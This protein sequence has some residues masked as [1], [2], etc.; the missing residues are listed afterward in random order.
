[1]YPQLTLPLTILFAAVAAWLVFLLVRRPVLRRLALRQVVRRP[2]ELVLVILGSMLGTALIVASL[3]V[4]DSLDRSVRQSAYD[5]LG[6]VD[7]LVRSP[8]VSVGDEVAR[9]LDELADDPDVDGVLTVRGDPAAAVLDQGGRRLAEPR[10]IAWEVDFAAAA[11]FGAPHPSGLS[12]ADPGPGRRGPERAPGRVPRCRR[13]RPGHVLRLRPA[14]AGDRRRRWCRPR[15]W[16]EW[17]WARPSTT[18][19]TSRPAH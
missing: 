13:R 11:E 8:S 5:V 15:V 4:G 3:A 18:V 10:A 12:I 17:A 16:E 14:A 6:P 19:P 9:R 7:E 1:M 2:A